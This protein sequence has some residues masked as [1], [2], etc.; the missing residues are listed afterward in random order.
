MFWSII[1]ESNGSKDKLKSILA[2]EPRVIVIDFYKE[3]LKAISNLEEI[4]CGGGASED[5]REDVF[6]LIVSKGREYYD[7]IVKHPECVPGDIDP[8]G[9]Y[10]LNVAGDVLMER[11]GEE[12]TEQ[13]S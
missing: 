5:Y 13:L 8:N 9:P 4:M 3:F 12:I 1:D 2:S 11:F 10:F 7:E 6:T